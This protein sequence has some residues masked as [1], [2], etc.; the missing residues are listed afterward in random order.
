VPQRDGRRRAI[1][2]ARSPAGP[3]LPTTP[4]LG[5]PSGHD[6]RDDAVFRRLDLVDIDLTGQRARSVEFEEC[7]FSRAT[8]AD[9]VLDRAAFTDCR[10]E[11]SN[12]ANVHAGKSSML[13]VEVSSARLTGLQW[14]NGTLR[15]VTFR[16]CRMDLAA[17]RFSGFKDVAFVDCKLTR[18]DFTDADLRGAHFTGCDLTGAQFTH[19]EAQ[20]ARFTRCE[21]V[22]LG[23]VAS[24]KGAVVSSHDLVALSHALAGALG[25]VID[26]D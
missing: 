3:R 26:D 17:F 2:A 16:E 8:L 1:G 22:G 19:S 15:D 9:A 4:E 7:R 25:I 6:L 23:G 12:W 18:S 10:V 21:L 13:R 14:L 20:G 5:V 11:H 24:L